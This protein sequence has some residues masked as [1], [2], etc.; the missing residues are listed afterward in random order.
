MKNYI[1][2]TKPGIILGNAITASSGFLLASRG[3]IEGL[4]F[5]A[6]LAGLS[7][8]IGSACVWNNWIDRKADAQMKRTQKR[9]LATGAIAPRQ[10]A[11]FALFLGLIGIFL[12]AAF[13]SLLTLLLAL[14]GLA[15]Y[16][17]VYSF[18]KYRSHYATWV[19]SIAGAAPPVVGY[20]AVTGHLDLAAWILFFI[21]AA[22]QIPHFFAISL[23][24]IE[25]Y[26]AASIP[27]LPRVKGVLATKVQMLLFLIVLI[28]ISSLLYFFGYVTYG[29]LYA[30]VPLGLAW[31]YLALQGFKSPDT[32]RWAKKMFFLSLIVITGMSAA[33]ALFRT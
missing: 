25:E 33:I 22:W 24:R 28:A 2:L 1:S 18:Y 23:F 17:F 3:R 12:L 20:T 4:L 9:A 27:V 7:C 14:A 30:S 8:I 6:T 26:A 29:Y 5:L 16:V 13:T 21:V 19:G 31:L 15:V 10:A 11:L 32:A